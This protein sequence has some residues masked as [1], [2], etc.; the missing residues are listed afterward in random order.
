MNK[1]CCICHLA[2]DEND[3]EDRHELHEGDCPQCDCYC[4][5]PAHAD[6]C[7]DKDCKRENH[8]L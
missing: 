3:W 6:C 8:E 5:L 2:I 4:D 7:T 1:L